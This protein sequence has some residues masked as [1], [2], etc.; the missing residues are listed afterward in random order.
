ML[1]ALKL[2]F[3]KKFPKRLNKEWIAF[4]A[5]GEEYVRKHGGLFFKYFGDDHFAIRYKAGDL[6]PVLE[7]GKEVAYYRVLDFK[8]EGGDLAGWDDGRKYNLRLHSIN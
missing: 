6:I 1:N 4:S 7:N 3:D 5:M 8:K 2:L